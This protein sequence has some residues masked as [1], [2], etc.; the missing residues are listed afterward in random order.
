[1]LLERLS[2]SKFTCRWW[3]A[4]GRPA[5]RLY[6]RRLN[7]QGQPLVDP[8]KVYLEFDK[9]RD[10]R[11]SRLVVVTSQGRTVREM[12]T[13]YAR[14]AFIAKSFDTPQEML[15]YKTSRRALDLP[16]GDDAA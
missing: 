4:A 2:Q 7:S 16:I 14:A 3:G 9:P 5:H 11:G 13:V 15:V 12:E 8:V 10:V 1:L 6:L